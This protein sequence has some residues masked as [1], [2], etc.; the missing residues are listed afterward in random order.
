MSCHERQVQ[1]Q[2]PGEVGSP[3]GDP[4]CPVQVRHLLLGV[5]DPLCRDVHGDH[6]LRPG[7]VGLRVGLGD[8]WDH[9]L[10]PRDGV[11]HRERRI[12]LQWRCPPTEIGRWQGEGA[13]GVR[14]GQRAHL[15]GYPQ[16]PGRRR[17]EDH[18]LWRARGK[19]DPWRRHAGG[20][21]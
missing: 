1:V 2:L 12:G 4:L 11:V 13:P 15:H 18:H 16:P 20:S 3:R 19:E 10:G 9:H 21:R 5:G 6:P 8:G 14:V 17:R 7:D